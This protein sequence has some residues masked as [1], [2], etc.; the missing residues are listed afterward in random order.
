MEQRE[1]KLQGE[2]PAQK[3]ASQRSKYLLGALD[4]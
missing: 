1:E 4:S 3:I 2:A